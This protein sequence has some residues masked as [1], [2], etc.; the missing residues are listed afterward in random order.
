MIN[1][2]SIRGR[3]SRRPASRLSASRLTAA[4][5]AGTALAGGLAALVPAGPAR[6]DQPGGIMNSVDMIGARA[7]WERGITGQGTVVVVIDSGVETSHPFLEGKVIDEA[8]VGMSAGGQTGDCGGG[9]D[10]ATGEG[11]AAPDYTDE[12]ANHGTHVA[13]TIAGNNGEAYGVAPDAKIAAILIKGPDGVDEEAGCG[14]GDPDCAGA[15]NDGLTRAYSHVMELAQ[16]YRV[17]AVN[18]SLG[19]GEYSGVCDEQTPGGAALSEA[20]QAAQASGIANV[21]ASGNEYHTTT[22]STPACLTGA[23]PVGAVDSN[24]IIA[25]FSNQSEL[26]EL[27][28]PG[29]G[30]VSSVFNGE[31]GEMDGTS[32][33]TP[34]V[35]GAIALLASASPGAS[36][37]E[38]YQA[39]ALTGK[40]V[41]YDDA[42]LTERVDEQGQPLPEKLVFRLI[43]VDKAAFLL[44][45]SR[46]DAM[47]LAATSDRGRVMGTTFRNLV[48]EDFATDPLTVY[49]ALDV[50]GR[51]GMDGALSQ[52]GPDRN[53]A[54]AEATLALLGEIGRT[55]SA[56]LG[57]VR[58]G[59]AGVTAAMDAPRQFAAAATVMADV[60]SGSSS[61]ASLARLPGMEG[62]E[63]GGWVRG[64]GQWLDRDATAERYGYRA[65]GGGVIAG[66][67]TIVGE[68][69]RVGG[70]TAYGRSS[71]KTDGGLGEGTADLATLGIYG[72]YTKDRYHLDGSLSVGYGWSET[73]RVIALPGLLR[74]A[75]G[76]TEGLTVQSRIALGATYDV[77]GWSVGPEAWVGYTGLQQ[78]GYTETG[79]GSLNA[80]VDELWLGEVGTGL[81]V[82]VGRGFDLGGPVLMPAVTLGM[83]YRSPTGDDS[84]TGVLGGTAAGAYN[85][86]LARENE[87]TFDPVV[88]AV[89]AVDGSTSA[90]ASWRGR[91]G[92]G[93]ADQAGTVGVRITW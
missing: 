46:A 67:D 11:T 8:C 68:G 10:F 2:G 20:F 87:L 81:G 60:T 91:F 77:S 82:T 53:T 37:N 90:Y 69:W 7:L 93:V 22:V 30:I 89:L 51:S 35:A 36:V 41:T 49:R 42:T 50:V 26:V 31:Y 15:L 58:Q 61:L 83:G 56:R 40:E 13:G 71:T 21:V 32:M 43:Q 16:Q 59:G 55:V 70:F 33:A 24:E 4:L 12:D 57:A 25:V 38:I 54:T 86:D 79:A 18:M 39:L 44:I 14:E 92:D 5:V 76:E 34:H 23:I 75:K 65:S 72:G 64:F 45:A 88:E 17:V 27:M 52:L 73:D 47:T 29:V 80:R 1:V 62:G 78:K 3:R 48:G 66:I 74:T 9:A 28:A 19:A 6:A 84:M 85:L 63:T